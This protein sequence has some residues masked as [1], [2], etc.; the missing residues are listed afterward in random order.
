MDV[1][2]T[3]GY[4]G[5]WRYVSVCYGDYSLNITLTIQEQEGKLKILQ[6]GQL[7]KTFIVSIVMIWEQ[8]YV[9]GCP[10]Y[11]GASAGRHNERTL[12]AFNQL[13]YGVFDVIYIPLYFVMLFLLK[14]G[15]CTW[16]RTPNI[17]FHFLFNAGVQLSRIPGYWLTAWLHEKHT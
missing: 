16:N 1:E 10:P 8:M 14:C 12:F 3:T 6:V 9:E 5:M 13:N 11:D 7:T 15:Q 2:W 4:A 17:L